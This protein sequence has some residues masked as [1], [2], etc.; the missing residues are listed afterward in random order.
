MCKKFHKVATL[1]CDLPRVAVLT[2]PSN[3]LSGNGAPWCYSH[4]FNSKNHQAAPSEI[5][6]S[7]EFSRFF[8][9]FHFS[10]S[11]SSHLSFTFNSRKGVKGICFS[12]FTSWK[13]VKAIWISLFFLEKKEWNLF[14]NV[15]YFQI[16]ISHVPVPPIPACDCKQ[17]KQFSKWQTPLASCNKET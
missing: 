4:L 16:W 12:L 17:K 7:R 15:K 3:L 8:L 6:V 5:L 2:T 13:K 10:F 14:K 1:G 9:N 11:I